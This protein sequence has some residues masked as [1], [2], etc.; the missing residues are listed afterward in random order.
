MTA[1]EIEMQKFASIKLKDFNRDQFHFPWWEQKERH[2]L[3]ILQLLGAG[4][5]AYV[6]RLVDTMY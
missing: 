3:T 2:T 1:L 6:R 4:L 5:F